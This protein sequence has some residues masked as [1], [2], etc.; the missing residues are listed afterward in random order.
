LFAR[1]VPVLL[2]ALLVGTSIILNQF[3]GIS[4]KRP[5]N[6][7]ISAMAA[8]LASISFYTAARNE[9]RLS[10]ASMFLLFYVLYPLFAIRLSYLAATLD[11]PLVDEKL[12]RFDAALGFSWISLAK[13]EA[14]H[15]QL[16]PIQAVFYE[17]HFL[18]VIV[19]AIIFSFVRP[20]R[21]NYE[22]LFL[23]LLGLLISVTL[24]A[25]F[26]AF[27]PASLAHIVM[28]HEK[29]LTQLRGGHYQN[30]PYDGIISFPSYHTIMAIVFVY[31][32]RG[33]KI[34][35]GLALI[36]NVVMVFTVP[37]GGDHYLSDMIA[38]AIIALACIAMSR[39][40]FVTHSSGS[41]R[42]IVET[43]SAVGLADRAAALVEGLRWSTGTEQGSD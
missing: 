40:I 29:L 12:E 4:W 18:Q 19:L 5:T 8:A 1:A 34:V 28:P 14:S 22:M 38:G 9:K 13:M 10:E 32:S 27:G 37:Y 30:L 16:L 15:P 3:V 6:I 25:V 20:F 39:L 26:P 42:G 23:L 2:F 7:E 17:S 21:R 36:W 11:F 31:C 33:I 43:G 24:L 41:S 35:S